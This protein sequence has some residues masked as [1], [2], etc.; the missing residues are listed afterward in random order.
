MSTPIV[1]IWRSTHGTGWCGQIIVNNTL[2]RFER[3][4]SREEVAQK[5]NDY[6]RTR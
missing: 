3:G 5:L 1:D 4:K 2:K 6:M